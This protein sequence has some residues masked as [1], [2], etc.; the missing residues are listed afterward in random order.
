MS[1]SWRTAL[2]RADAGGSAPGGGD[3][4]VVVADRGVTPR[5]AADLV[6]GR[7]KIFG[8]PR[9]NPGPGVHGH[10]LSGIGVG[11]Q[12]ALECAG[13]PV[14][15]DEVAASAAGIGPYPVIQA[16]LSSPS[17][18]CRLHRQVGW[19]G[20]LFHWLHQQVRWQ[21]RLFHWLHRQVR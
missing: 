3:D 19:Q 14:S 20:R 5:R 10:Q 4:V 21:G 16:G 15:A 2:G 18:F 12:P 13:G 6:P 11:E 7:S 1:C 8:W 9:G 17:S